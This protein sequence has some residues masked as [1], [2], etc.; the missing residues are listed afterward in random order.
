MS[1]EITFNE[2][3]RVAGVVGAGGAGFPTY[4]KYQTQAELV[5]A[6]GAECEPLLWADKEIMRL[7]ANQ[8][9]SGL[10]AVMASVGAK[11]GI[12][13][14]KEK[15]EDVV[16]IVKKA[17]SRYQVEIFLLKDFYPAGDE[18]VLI[19]EVTGKSLPPGA[20]PTRHGI[21]INNV[22]TLL[23]VKGAL[24]GKPVIEKW[25]TVTGAVANPSTFVV[26]IGTPLKVLIEAAGGTTVEDYLIIAGGPMMGEISSLESP[27]TKT[28]KGVIVLPRNLPVGTQRIKSLEET[29]RLSKKFC[30]QCAYCTDMCPRYLIG[31]PLEPHRIM[32]AFGYATDLSQEIFRTSFLCCECGV[33]TVVACPMGISPMH[34][35]R[36]LKQ[37]LSQ[38]GIRYEPRDLGNRE[39]PYREYRL[40]PLKRILQRLGISN[41]DRYAPYTKF[42]KELKEVRLPLKQHTGNPAVP[43]VKPGDLV[44][45]GDLIA[46]VTNGLGVPIHA[47]LDGVIREVTSEAI[48]IEGE[49]GLNPEGGECVKQ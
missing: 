13:A 19:Y 7:K 20:I 10:R 22:E 41:L 9:A 49:E 3:V 8:V 28:T 34:V 46:E 14:L 29:V 48:V 31:H 43:I 33:C 4:I 42:Q 18:H 6:N 44:K 12:I 39:R 36:W 27:V 38:R 11:R 35:N 24:T 21:V 26:P 23:N 16:K 47:S 1:R 17:C 45:K 30:V 2:K 40:I 37:E 32:R 25:V 15:Y 5:I